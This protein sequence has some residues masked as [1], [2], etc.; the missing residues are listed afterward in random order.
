MVIDSYSKG[1]CVMLS[2]IQPIIVL[3]TKRQVLAGMNTSVYLA[4]LALHFLSSS[5]WLVPGF[6]LVLDVVTITRRRVRSCVVF[7]SPAS[8]L[9]FL[10]LIVDLW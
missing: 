3:T 2:I 8:A 5:F 1:I 6:G 4:T 9:C 10:I 7:P